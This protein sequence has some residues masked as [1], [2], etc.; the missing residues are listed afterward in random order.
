[1][2]L[3]LLVMLNYA[4]FSQKGKDT[5]CVNRADLV[6]KLKQVER[7]KVDSA[8]KV[9][10][11]EQLEE[12]NVIIKHRSDLIQTLEARVQNYE[13][14]KMNYQATVNLQTETIK[15]LNSALKKQKRKTTAITI[16]GSLIVGGLT[17]LLI[18]K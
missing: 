2:L 14:Q 16:A 5:I 13:L 9:V 3:I 4:G 8:E 15:S 11:V 7:L 18:T 6:N 17:Y 1:M 12:A 10:F